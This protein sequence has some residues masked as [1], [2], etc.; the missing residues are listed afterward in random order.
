MQRQQDD[1]HDVLAL[2][3]IRTPRLLLRLFE[4]RD[5]DV[6][7]RLQSDP[8]V[9]RYLPYG[10]RTRQEVQ[11]GLAKRMAPPRM[12][13]NDDVLQLVM[14]RLD[15]DATDGGVMVGELTLFLRS[16]QHRQGE[17]G[18][19]LVPEE[20]GQGLGAEGARALLTLAFE[21]LGLH[22]MAGVCDPRNTASA[23]MMLR[24]GMRQ[25]AHLRECEWFKGEWGSLLTF[26]LLEDEWRA[27]QPG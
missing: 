7:H 26:G 16:V 5:L 17:L 23:A 1:N 8:E 11:S 22:R 14:E 24:L 3:P 27:G 15:A 4:P 21:G 9:T 6:Q 13:Q 18:F 10:P 20:R 19:V 25:E 12:T 2:L